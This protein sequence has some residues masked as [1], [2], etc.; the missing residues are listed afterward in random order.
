MSARITAR[1]RRNAKFREIPLT[2]PAWLTEAPFSPKTSKAVTKRKAIA[3]PFGQSA[4][5]DQHSSITISGTLRANAANPLPRMHERARVPARKKFSEVFGRMTGRLKEQ[6]PVWKEM[7]LSTRN[8]PP[9]ARSAGCAMLTRRFSR[10]FLLLGMSVTVTAVAAFSQERPDPEAAVRKALPL[11]EKGATG[12]IKARQCFGCHHTHISVLAL[13]AA[14]EKGLGGEGAVLEAQVKHTLADL[15]SALQSYKDGKGQGGQATRAGYA[16][17]TLDL[18]G[19]KANE[20]TEAVASYLTRWPGNSDFWPTS[21]TQ[22][23][24]TE[25]SSFTSTYLALRGLKFAAEA[26]KEAAEMRREK[27]LQWLLGATPKDTEDAVFRLW[28]LREASAAP[29]VVREAIDHLLSRQDP[30]GGWRQIDGL[31]PDAYAT[32]TAL[33]ALNRAGR[34]PPSNEAYQRG[35]A[36]L[37]KSQL[38]DGS[39][40]VVTRAKGFQ[41]YFESGFPHGKDQWISMA[42]T[43]WATTALAIAVPEKKDGK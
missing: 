37:L 39:W 42:A 40:H 23:P 35:V 8:L 5:I 15:T 32:G 43:G 27:A 9:L 41:T 25:G 30:G 28:A 20:T 26:Q 34:V 11:L 36:F 33:V 12:Y 10:L 31:D 7:S 4:L 18:G 3:S 19:V 6:P 29:F 16:L 14:K 2:R 22:R 17:W 1:A 13:S 38:P 24:P 21:G